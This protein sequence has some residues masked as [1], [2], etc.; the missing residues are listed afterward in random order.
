MYQ[1]PDTNKIEIRVQFSD[2]L[3]FHFPNSRWQSESVKID[4][5]QLRA[6]TDYK[7]SGQNDLF[8]L[9]KIAEIEGVTFFS[10]KQKSQKLW[11]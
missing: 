10:L 11:K 2:M 1:P 4:L 7:F 3:N 5:D 8:I 9:S 6:E